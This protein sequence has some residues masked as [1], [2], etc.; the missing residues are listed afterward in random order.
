[1]SE[2]RS[3]TQPLARRAGSYLQILR[4]YLSGG[5]QRSIP[6]CTQ[7]HS[8]QTRQHENYSRSARL[9]EVRLHEAGR[10]RQKKQTYGA[11]AEIPPLLAC[12]SNRHQ[13]IRRSFCKNLTPDTEKG[14]N[15][16]RL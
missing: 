1:M 10:P 3:P 14:D 15:S 11:R 16:E 13:H 4:L 5:R 9:D 2:L 7:S 8:K 6:A 12:T